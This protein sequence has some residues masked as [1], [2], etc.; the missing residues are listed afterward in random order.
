VSRL[1]PR[2]CLL[3]FAIIGFISFVLRSHPIA[4][5]WNVSNILGSNCSDTGSGTTIRPFCSLQVGV[6]RARPGDTVSVA[7][8]TYGPA[9]LNV[10]ASG[11]AS[12]PIV[13]RATP[14]RSAVIIGAPG[15]GDAA[16]GGV[17]IT[18][19]YV[20][21]QGFEVRDAAGTGIRNWGNYVTIRDN[22]VHDNA[23]RCSAGVKCGQ[24]IAS[25]GS[26]PRL[27]VVIERNLSFRN[28]TSSS[29]DHGF[30]ISNPGAIVRNN[31]AVA[32]GGFG[33]QI[34]PNCD[35]CLI[36]NNVAHGNTRNSGFLIGGDGS[37]SFTSNA[38]V[39]NNISANN[40]ASGFHIYRNGTQVVTM[41]NNIAHGNAGVGL[42]LLASA[43]PVNLGFLQ[44][45]PMLLAPAA[46]DFHLRAASPAID[47]GDQGLV[48]PDDIDGEPRPFGARV[49]IGADEF[50]GARPPEVGA[51]LKFTDGKT[52][53]WTGVAAASTY[54]VYR[55]DLSSGGFSFDHQCLAFGLTS[56]SFLDAQ[57]PQGEAFYYL[58]A[59][60]NAAGEGTLGASSNG[61]LR[62]NL[63]PCY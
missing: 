4:A 1:R 51:D 62:P 24:G 30:Y 14:R 39:Y 34:Y 37:S 50:S 6:N 49:D 33:F 38:K 63:Y 7:G 26:S 11:T 17:I 57:L 44:V 18:G 45:D 58:V 36:Y 12:A 35:G 19:S 5:T 31:V 21:F 28:G 16:G 61:Q 32:A 9:Q 40:G 22:Y 15:A 46:L 54:S 52:L 29:Q 42:S 20:V 41:R 2:R 8:G 13:I 47:S 60:A 53:V 27:G 3:V 25:N 56:P 59:G 48:P 55:G 23:R 10:Q 43:L